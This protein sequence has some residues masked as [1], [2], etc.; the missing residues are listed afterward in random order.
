LKME[1]RKLFIF[2]LVMLLACTAYAQ[3]RKGIDVGKLQA[4][5]FDD[6]IQSSTN[7]PMSHVVYRRGYYNIPWDDIETNTYWP[8][9]FLRNAATLV[10]VRNWTDTLGNFWPYHVTGHC[11]R[12]S[13][14]PGDPYQFSIPDDLGYTIHR[15][16]AFPPPQIIVDGQHMEM[17]FPLSG[18]AVAPSLIWGTADVMVECHYRL[19][20]GIDV[21]QRNLAW[22]QK[23]LDDVVFWDL[24]FVN[25][26]NTDADEEIELPGQR[27]DSVVI[28]KH[29][30]SLPNGGLYPW[31]AWAGVTENDTT[32]LS[33]PQ[34]DDSLRIN[35]VSLARK[36]GH[37]HDSYGDK[38]EIDWGGDPNLEDGCG[39][40]G[41]ATLFAPKNTS[42]P[43]TYPIAN[44]SASNDP[45]Q[46]SMHSTIEDFLGV[47]NYLGDLTDTTDFREPYRCMRKGIRGYDDTTVV[48]CTRSFR[49]SLRYD[50]YDTTAMGAPTYY[51]IPQDRLGEMGLGR[52]VWFPRTLTYYTFCTA[53]KF[54]IGPY[55]M[56]FG[57]TIRFVFAQIAG[58]VN[59]KTTYELSYARSIN[60]A[61]NFEWVAG[62]DSATIRTEYCK[63]DPTA[64]IYGRVLPGII[65]MGGGLNEIATDY[66]ISTGKDSL[67][68][69][70]MAAQRAF[71][72]NYEVP[73]SPAPPSVF[74]VNSRPD[75]IE[76]IWSYDEAY[77]PTNL[78]G[79]K[80]YRAQGGTK[81]VRASD[82]TVTGDWIFVDSVGPTERSFE[83][84]AGVIPGFDYYYYITAVSTSGIESGQFLTMTQEPFAARLT[85]PP[86]DSLEQIRIVPNPFNLRDNQWGGSISEE[87][88]I[89][90]RNLPGECTIRI[91]TESGELVK[92][93]VHDDGSGTAFWQV[94]G[95][96]AG[97]GYMTTEKNQRPASGLYIAHIQKPDGTWIAQKF[98]II[99]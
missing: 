29:Y 39:F 1:R 48:E 45:A 75:M 24:T 44:I 68:N 72:M 90:F 78:A 79:F 40:T 13:Y 15:Y 38:C 71:N 50:V 46:P 99:R 30:E 89:T 51:E 12:Q 37:T 20:N 94:M 52:G 10:G 9:G 70:G 66:V 2:L 5:I 83:D 28:M 84:T 87:Y 93:I 77:E 36:D 3:A 64:E 4:V 22:S 6:G 54:S 82:G 23:S 98:V 19:S 41:L 92:T 32:R 81:Y 60:Q 96:A 61:R 18:D 56:E 58:A 8:G 95:A 17:P 33:Y 86:G 47:V 11:S 76:L 57:D 67:F 88:K 55:T 65:W 80:I 59:R 43:Q 74:E 73:A 35:F 31:G 91:F 97:G 26:G 16:F 21:Y 34:D 69:N 14:G 27:L 49:M 85:S 63:R 7:L 25:T 42:V 53:P 62:M